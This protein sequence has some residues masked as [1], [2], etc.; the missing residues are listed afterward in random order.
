MLKLVFQFRKSEYKKTCYIL[1]NNF[2]KSISKNIKKK[3]Y[4]IKAETNASLILY[5]WWI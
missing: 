4:F 3:N 5:Q 1:K 2:T